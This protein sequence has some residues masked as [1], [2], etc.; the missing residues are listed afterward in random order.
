M[1]LK[2]LVLLKEIVKTCDG[3]KSKSN[4]YRNG[5]CANVPITD[6]EILEII[7]ELIFYKKCE[8]LHRLEHFFEKYD[9]KD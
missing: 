1:L 3:C 4:C 7:D 5:F 8:K 2:E 9:K 6:K